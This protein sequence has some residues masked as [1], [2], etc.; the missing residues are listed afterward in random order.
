M[1]RLVVSLL[2]AL[3]FGLL[4][5]PTGY[6]QEETGLIRGLVF[7]DQDR[8]GV[9]DPGEIGLEETVVCIYKLGV[10]WCDHTEGGSYMFDMLPPQTYKIKLVDFP[11]GYHLISKRVVKVELQAGEIRTDVHFALTDELGGGNP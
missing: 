3:V 8:D 1:K 10:D 4:I 9:M 2:V 5:A 6:A 11:H 7:V